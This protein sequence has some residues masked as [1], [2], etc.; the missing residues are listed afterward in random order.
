ML[1]VKLECQLHLPRVICLV[2]DL[3]ELT[4]VDNRVRG[5]ELWV[6]QSVE[7]FCAKFLAPNSV[8]D[9]GEFGKITD[10]A[11]RRPHQN[12]R[13]GCRRNID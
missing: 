3:A 8:I 10:Q 5:Q 7:S 11:V 13:S 1:P 12:N 4:T 2:G 6:V 9:S